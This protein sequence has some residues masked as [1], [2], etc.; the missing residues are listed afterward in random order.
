MTLAA[1]GWGERRQSEFATHAAAGLVPGRVV[2]EHRSHHRVAT[3][4]IELSPE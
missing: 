4:A 2:S 1:L 3:D